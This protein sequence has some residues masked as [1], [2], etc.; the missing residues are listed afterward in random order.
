MK[1]N[2]TIIKPFGLTNINQ[3]TALLFSQNLEKLI[4]SVWDTLQG[5]GRQYVS[6][7]NLKTAEK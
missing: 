7:T 4:T 3:Y 1:M 6:S 5:N 2:F